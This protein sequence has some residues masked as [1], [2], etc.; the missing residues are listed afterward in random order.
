MYDPITQE[1]YYQFRA[2]FEPHQVRTDRVPG[3]LDIAKDGLV[4]VFDADPD[5]KT[6][7]FIRG[8]DRNPDRRSRS[9][10]A[11]RRRWAARSRIEPV[12]LPRAGLR[13]GPAARSSWPTT[14]PR[15]RRSRRSPQGAGRRAPG[16]VGRLR[17]I[18]VGAR[19]PPAEPGAGD[20]GD[21]GA[22][23]RRG[24]TV[25]GRGQARRAGRGD[26]GRGAGGGR[27]EGVGGLDP[28][29]DRG[30]AGPA[31]RRRPRRPA[32]A[33]RRAAGAALGPR[34]GPG[35]GG[36]KVG[37]RRRR[38]WRRRR[39]RPEG[40]RPRRIRSGRHQTYP[41]TS[42]GRRLAFARW[43][44]DRD[45]P[46]TARVAVNHIWLRHFGQALVPSVFDFGRNGRPPSHPA[47]LD[48]LAAEFM[49][50]GW[51]MKALHRLIVTSSA[52]RMASTPDA[53]RPRPR[54][55]QR[56]PLADEPAPR[57]RPR[58]CAT[59]SSRRRQ[60]RPD[61]GRPGHRPRPGPDR[62]RGAASTSA[63]PPRSR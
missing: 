40:P 27:P 59:A 62:R 16:R 12:T 41:A 54:P 57:W 21:R 37:R 11:C 24:G 53:G 6:Y 61:D 17:P 52:Y 26:A 25:A 42:T 47:L 51:S 20:P 15:A 35:R 63:T 14:W 32:Q 55:R 50:R 5:A 45:N 3:Q 4:R 56:L 48:W 39:P 2:I 23:P 10:P 49:E 7:L 13:S 33:P 38:R 60:A 36:Q 22:D 28:G 9:R 31:G 30:R 34:G 46:L 18:L 29:G 58:W 44:A 1:E 43:I 19:S 8:D